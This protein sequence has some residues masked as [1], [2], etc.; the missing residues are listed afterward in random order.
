ME[1]LL[2]LTD[3]GLLKAELDEMRGR[4]ADRERTIRELYGKLAQ[5]DMEL[6]RLRVLERLVSKALKDGALSII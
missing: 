4:V 3:P 2:M 1:P 6:S 5:K